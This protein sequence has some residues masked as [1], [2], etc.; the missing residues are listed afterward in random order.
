MFVGHVNAQRKTILRC[1]EAET[2]LRLNCRWQ[3]FADALK[4]GTC[5]ESA[6][7]DTLRARPPLKKRIPN[8]M[9]MGT[10][11]KH[12]NNDPKKKLAYGSALPNISTSFPP[13]T[14]KMGIPNPRS[15]W[16]GKFRENQDSLR[17]PSQLQGSKPPRNPKLPE[18]TQLPQKKLKKYSKIPGNTSFFLG[19]GGGTG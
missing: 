1:K 15:G 16:A 14:L 11:D 17:T 8:W 12:G 7:P 2:C 6:C 9:K 3:T 4:F 13:K 18:T 5:I 10:K 19:G